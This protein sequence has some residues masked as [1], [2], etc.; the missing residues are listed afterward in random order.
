MNE[1]LETTHRRRLVFASA[2]AT[3]IAL[4]SIRFFLIPYLT[5]KPFVA[6]DEIAALI[7]DNLLVALISSMVVTFLVLWLVPPSRRNTA[8]EV[9]EPQRM[10]E[11]LQEAHKGTHEWWY[12]GAIGRHFRTSTL[13][14]LAREAKA[15]KISKRIHLLVL[16]PRLANKYFALTRTRLTVE[17]KNKSWTEE[18]IKLEIYATILT[19]YAFKA[20]EPSLEIEVGL[21]NTLSVY[22]VDL[23]SKLALITTEG[24]KDS[25][26]KCDENSFYYQTYREDLLLSFQQSTA[27]P[28]NVKGIPLEKL[29]VSLTKVLLN[30]LGINNNDLS[31]KNIEEIINKIQKVRN[32]YE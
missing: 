22:R 9:V 10:R 32:P 8:I 23:S 19:T 7:I 29:N 2:I 21:L 16:D 5:N 3:L 12:R 6:I 4:L 27:L 1:L 28:T 24:I 14:Q 18:S 13:P 30:E 17:E 26:I 15:E 31:D 25:A 20:T 11:V